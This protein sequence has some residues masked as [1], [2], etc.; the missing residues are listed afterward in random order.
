LGKPFYSCYTDVLAWSW[1][2]R[3]CCMIRIQCSRRCR[4]IS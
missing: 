2:L 3:M 1:M 4:S